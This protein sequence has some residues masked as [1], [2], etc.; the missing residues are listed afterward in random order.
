MEEKEK[1]GKGKG[2]FSG[3]QAVD[4]RQFEDKSWC[5]QRDLRV[6]AKKLEFRQTSSGRIFS[7]LVYF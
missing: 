5:T 6:H 1:E 4:V 3:F 2:R 7:Y